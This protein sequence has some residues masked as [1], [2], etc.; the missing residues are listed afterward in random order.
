MCGTELFAIKKSLRRSGFTEPVQMAGI[1]MLFI[2]G[3]VMFPTR[4]IVGWFYNGEDEFVFLLADGVERLIFTALMLRFA[5]QFGF[6][7]VSF[8]TRAI[9]YLTVLPALLVAVNNFPFVSFFSGDCGLNQTDNVLSFC[10][11]CVGVGLFEEVSFR[12]IIYPLINISIYK[13]CKEGSKFAFLKNR[14]VFWTIALSGTV[15]ALTHLVNLFN[16]NIGGTFLQVG[17]TFLIGCM[18][19]IVTAKTGNVYFSA[20][21][22]IVYNF[23]GMFIDYCGY[24]RMWTVPQIICT[25]VA[26]VILGAYLIFVAFRAD[27]HPEPTRYMLGEE[28]EFTAPIDEN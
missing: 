25:A 22:H 23:C 26:G 18:C 28:D 9:S 15:F 12:G 5:A 19:G 20:L 10:V 16:G 24:G 13:H 3:V 4:R 6:R 8:K 27:R 2:L 21:V 1:M 11:W 14:P 17:Y 7:L